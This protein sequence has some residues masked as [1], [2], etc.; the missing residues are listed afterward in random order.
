MRLNNNIVIEMYTIN[1]VEEESTCP[2]RR[3]QVTTGVQERDYPLVHRCYLVPSR[4]SPAFS[5]R[6]S[7][8]TLSTIVYHISLSSYSSAE[9]I[10]M[11]YLRLLL[12]SN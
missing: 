11:A 4:N 12:T 8:M 10:K 6:T 2:D 3:S 1:S 7:L 5:S 9:I